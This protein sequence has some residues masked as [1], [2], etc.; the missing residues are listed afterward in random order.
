MNLI[1]VLGSVE[2]DINYYILTDNP[3]DDYFELSKKFNNIYLISG[4]DAVEPFYSKLRRGVN[5]AINNIIEKIG[6]NYSLN[7]RSE[8]YSVIRKYN[9]DIVHSP[10]QSIPINLEVPSI[11]TPHDVQELHYPQFFSS[12]QRMVRAINNH[13]SI[14]NST[15]II[16][17]YEHIKKDLINCFGIFDSKV[18]VILLNM[19]NLWFNRLLDLKT[20]SYSPSKKSYILYPAATW[21]HKN[22][23]KLLEA[24]FLLKNK[25]GKLVNLI[26]TGEKTDFYEKLQNQCEVLGLQNQIEFKGIVSDKELYTLYKEAKA[27]VIPTL[28][29]AGSFPL[30]ESIFLGVPVV[31]SNVTSL[32]ATIGDNDFVF[33]PNNSIDIADKVEKIIYDNSYISKNLKLLKTRQQF[34]S[35][36]DIKNTVESLYKR[37]VN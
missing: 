18:N 29:E 27:V 22:H 6:V 25:K 20:N 24:L 28:Y 37:I 36:N 19:D 1:S 7:V 14:N 21:E 10:H 13:N 26:C 35:N 15:A 2:N 34:Y 17:S 11:V 33:D 8:I 31:C 32:P 23:S 30:Y 12:E 16:V 3:Q 9:I 5:R 4:S